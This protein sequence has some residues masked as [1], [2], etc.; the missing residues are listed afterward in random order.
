M[1]VGKSNVASLSRPWIPCYDPLFPVAY[2]V[3]CSEVM[4]AYHNLIMDFLIHVIYVVLVQLSIGLCKREIM[5][6]CTAYGIFQLLL[7]LPIKYKKNL[8]IQFI[9]S[10]YF[11]GRFSLSHSI[12]R[13]GKL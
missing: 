12:I 2:G 4:E 6:C 3:K 8:L 13:Q 7:Q 11:T 5:S 10:I 1:S 9:C